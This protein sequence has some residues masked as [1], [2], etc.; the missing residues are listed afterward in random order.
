MKLNFVFRAHRLNSILVVL[1]LLLACIKN[2]VENGKLPAEN[3][4]KL[5]RGG[6][7]DWSPTGERL[8]FIWD[9]N[10]CLYYFDD[11]HIEKVTENATEPSFSP[12]GKKIA[13][14]RERKIYTIDL[15][16]KQERYLAE[17]ITP[18]WSE[19][20]KWIVFANKD[21]SRSLTDGTIVYGSP[22]QDSCLYY[23]DLTFG[24]V[25]SV[26][27]SLFWTRWERPPLS[28]FE[29]EWAEGDS[30]V[31][32]TTEAGIWKVRRWGG[33]A[34]PAGS[35][36]DITN[37]KLSKASQYTWSAQSCWNTKYRLM[38]FFR[39]EDLAP[40][41]GIW[42]YIYIV[43]LKLYASLGG[44]GAG[45]HPTWSPSGVDIAFFNS[46]DGYLW[47]KDVSETVEF[48]VNHPFDP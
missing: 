28:F 6:Y 5:T 35:N 38:A 47:E 18:S 31:L 8:A 43:R 25:E 48:L 40:F 26:R 34:V 19:N 14:E 13:F 41:G 4:Y 22:T 46:E 20:G 37:A 32:F 29:P 1:L 11:K 44:I 45:S 30:T 27:V 42:R 39:G 12:D 7:P 21:A 15:E 16:T 3:P 17:G 9:N 23:Y 10:L 24:Q 2:P 33:K 36:F